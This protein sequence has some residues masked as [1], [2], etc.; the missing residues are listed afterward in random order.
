MARTAAALIIGNEILTGKIQET[1]MRE[2]ATELFKLGISLERA[3]GS[4][5]P[6]TT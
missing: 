2:L 1:N 6:T 4:D 5:P 3:V